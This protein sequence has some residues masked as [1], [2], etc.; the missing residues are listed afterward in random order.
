MGFATMGMTICGAM[1]NPVILACAGSSAGISS[2]F[3]GLAVFC[4]IVIVLIA[5]FCEK[6]A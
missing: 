2:L 1:I 5:A 3:W 6:H 4:A